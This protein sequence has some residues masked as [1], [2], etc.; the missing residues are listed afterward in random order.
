MDDLIM[1]A[2]TAEALGMLAPTR[3]S[4]AKLLARSGAYIRVRARD[5]GRPYFWRLDPSLIRE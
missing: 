3:V 2:E 5:T 4:Q 1:K